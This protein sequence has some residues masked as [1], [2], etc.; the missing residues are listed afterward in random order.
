MNAKETVKILIGAVQ[1]GDFAKITSLISDE[2]QFSGPVPEPL[3]KAQMLSLFASMKVA[4]PNLNYHFSIAG[5]D[6]SRVRVSSQLSGTH[7]GNLDL[8]V[9][10]MGEIAATRNSFSVAHEEAVITVR[11][12]RVVS[13]E[14]QPT[15]DAGLLAVLSQLNISMQR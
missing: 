2:F 1:A 5:T 3:S 12:F 4:F 11:D 13:W 9:L 10:G 15:K 6:G 14:V 7:M 8:T